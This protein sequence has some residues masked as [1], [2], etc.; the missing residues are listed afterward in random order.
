MLERSTKGAPKEAVLEVRQREIK[1]LVDGFFDWVQQLSPAVRPKSELGEAIGYAWNNRENFR[2]FLDRPEL[3]LHNNLAELLLRS[4]VVGRKNWLFAGSEGGAQGAAT[5]YTVI[6][7][8]ML[9]GVDPLVYLADVFDRLLDHPAN[10]MHELTP[11][12]WRLA[13]EA[14]ARASASPR[15]A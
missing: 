7:S 5:I 4:P 6:G 14:E 3:P 2:L 8:C 13:R 9:Q 10:R 12:G 1:P 11:L 15:P